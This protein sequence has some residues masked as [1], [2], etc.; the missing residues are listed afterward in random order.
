M[1]VLTKLGDHMR[2]SGPYDSCQRDHIIVLARSGSNLCEGMRGARL[3]KADSRSTIYWWL[4][5]FF[6]SLGLAPNEPDPYF[7]LRVRG[8]R[9]HNRARL[10]INS[11]FLRRLTATLVPSSMITSPPSPRMYFF[12]WRVLIR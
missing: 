9:F 2:F 11:C 5:T 1:G 10:S 3:T 12:T 7:D 6:R 8:P 4:V